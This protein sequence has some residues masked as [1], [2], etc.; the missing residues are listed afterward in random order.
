MFHDMEK[1][2]IAGMRRQG[3]LMVRPRALGPPSSMGNPPRIHG[4]AVLMQGD[5]QDVGSCQ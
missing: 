1:A 2:V 5:E 4:P 3:M